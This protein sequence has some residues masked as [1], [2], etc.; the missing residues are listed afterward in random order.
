VDSPHGEHIVARRLP[1]HFPR[2]AMHLRLVSGNSRGV[3]YG[4]SFVLF[5]LLV[6]VAVVVVVLLVYLLVRRW[7]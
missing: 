1:D 5:A 4:M 6:V 3:G 2:V 7:L